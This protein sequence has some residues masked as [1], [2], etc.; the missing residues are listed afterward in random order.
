MATNPAQQQ[1]SLRHNVPGTVYVLHFRARLQARPALHRLDQRRR[2][3]RPPA[4]HLQA[5]A[6]PYEAPFYGMPCL[7]LVKPR[8]RM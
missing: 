2:R 1:L 6:G 7:T 4:S 3:D 8:T 5:A